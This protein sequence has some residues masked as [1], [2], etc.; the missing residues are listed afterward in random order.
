V[1]SICCGQLKIGL[2]LDIDPK[3][4]PDIL[5]DMFAPPIR[6]HSFDTVL[7]DPPYSYFNRFKWVVR[8]ADI[9]RKRV[10]LSSNQLFVKLAGFKLTDIIAIITNNLFF[11]R[12]WYVYDR[13]N[14]RLF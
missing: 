1:I 14:E 3:V 12:L 10:I 7:I 5:A 13:I 9:S 4:K 8:I 2:T 11:V 6:K